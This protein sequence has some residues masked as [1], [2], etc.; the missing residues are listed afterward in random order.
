MATIKRTITEV[1]VVAFTEAI[2]KTHS[3]ATGTWPAGTVGA[4]VSDYG[5]MKEV[6]IADD[7]GVPL[8]FPVVPVKKL[9][10]VSKHSDRIAADPPIRATRQKKRRKP[11]RATASP[12]STS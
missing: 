2:D 12:S 3:D 1:D 4:V 5:T 9:E 6:E 10:L 7:R 11:Q 8:D